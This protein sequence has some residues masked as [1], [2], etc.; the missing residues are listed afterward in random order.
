MKKI[1]MN[2]YHPGTN[3]IKKPIST[4]KTIRLENPPKKDEIRNIQTPEISSV[5]RI[6][7]GLKFPSSSY[8][9]LD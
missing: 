3:M 2:S 6:R 7:Q 1:T 4:K 8:K 9:K 5:R